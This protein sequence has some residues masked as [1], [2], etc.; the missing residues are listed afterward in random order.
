[1]PDEWPAP[2]PEVNNGRR[3]AKDS[4]DATGGHD[5]AP[6]EDLRTK[7]VDESEAE[8]LKGGLR[9]I[10]FTKYQDKSTPDLS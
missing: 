5:K 8:Q 2:I 1:V 6:I 9:D 3:Q 4:N 7:K 10:S